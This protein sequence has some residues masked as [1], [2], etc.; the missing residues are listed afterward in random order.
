MRN[1]LTDV[2]ASNRAPVAD[3]GAE[4]GAAAEPR[5]SVPEWAFAIGD[6]LPV[7]AGRGDARHW[8]RVIP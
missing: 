6:T 1:Q 2:E 4:R 3:Q 5:A 7:I 8:P